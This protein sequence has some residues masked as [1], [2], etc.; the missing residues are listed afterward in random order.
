MGSIE[1]IMNYRGYVIEIMQDD[2][3][4]NP[5]KEFDNPGQIVLFEYE[6]SIPD[7]FGDIDWFHFLFEF[8]L[9][10]M[11]L[12]AGSEE[13][14]AWA[15]VGFDFTEDQLDDAGLDLMMQNKNFARVMYEKLSEK[16]YFVPFSYRS[17]SYN[18][19]LRIHDPDFILSGRVNGMIYIGKDEAKKAWDDPDKHAVSSLTSVLNTFQSYL[20]GDVYGYVIKDPKT[21]E[22]LDACWGY[23]GEQSQSFEFIAHEARGFIDGHINHLVGKHI[24]HLKR[25][26]KSR[27]PLIYR[28]PFCAV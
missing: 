10:T 17:T 11:N 22:E 26:I 9:D 28:K 12:N 20:L 7:V 8:I 23:Y 2:D 15:R 4:L 25:W 5:L 6:R 27:V 19:D 1:E 13:F 24:Q 21:R 16:Y 14:Y 3:P 18:S